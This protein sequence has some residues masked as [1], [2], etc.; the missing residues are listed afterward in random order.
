ML[1]PAIVDT[2]RIITYRL[3]CHFW[4]HCLVLFETAHK[5][6]EDRVTEYIYLST[7]LFPKAVL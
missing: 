4:H 6:T 2:V 7:H 1:K 3:I 5:T